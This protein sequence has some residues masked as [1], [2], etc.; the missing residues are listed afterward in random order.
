M[1][2]RMLKKFTKAERGWIMYDWANSSFSAIIA[3]IILPNFYATLTEGNLAAGTWWGYAT[4]LATLICA[5]LAPFLGTMGDYRGY[6]K[7]FFTGFVILGVAATAALTFTDQ[8]QVILI[9][10]VLGTIGFNGSCVFYDGFLPDV[11][12]DDRMDAVSTYGYGLGYIGG[13][14]IP[15]LVGMV[16]IMFGESFGVN[17]TLACQLSF[18]LTAVWWLVFTVPMWR[19]VHQVNSVEPEG[20]VFSQTL[21]RMGSLLRRI[22][23]CKGLLL[24]LLAYFFYIDGVGTIIHMATV[25][26]RNMGLDSNSLIVVLLLVQIVAFPFAILYGKFSKRIGVRNMI[27]VGIGTYMA[28]CF[29]ALLLKPLSAMGSTPLLMGF[30][31]LGFLVGTAQGGIQ[32][33]SRSYYGK[34]IPAESAN[35]YFGFFDI[36]GKF[37]AVIG[38]ALFSL[39]WG[40]TQ[41]VYLG[42][43]PVLVMFVI[44]MALFLTVP[45]DMKKLE[46]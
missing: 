20:H 27:C 40:A 12:T 42:I 37:S 7:R 19:H 35:E 22:I 30:L 1:F 33:L 34:L 4:S 9:F 13:S 45:K 25:F 31:A 3:A 39:V 24:F 18:L 14:T 28:V 26:G 23:R 15:L 29:V 10:Y 17:A 36:F 41:Q 46:K 44:G 21:R 8:W 11:T 16:L 32:A 2:E 5:V 43:I 38:P 6:K